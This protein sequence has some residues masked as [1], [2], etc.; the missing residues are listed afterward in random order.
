[1]SLFPIRILVV[2]DEPELCILSK[3]FLDIPG[4]INVDIAYSV[5]EARNALANVRY[6][7]IVSDYQMAGEDGIQ[8]LKSLRS[9]GDNTPF[10]LFTGK[11]REE[12]VI[13]AL[14]NGA[15]AYLQKGGMPRPMYAELE[16]RIRAAAAKRLADEENAR[17]LSILESTMESTADGILVADGK[18]GIVL[19]NK[20][21]KK[22][23]GIPEDIIQTKDDDLVLNFVI[24]QLKEPDKFIRTVRDL[25]SVPSKISFDVLELNDGRVFE[26]YSQPQRIGESV[27]GRVWS[28]RDITDQRK[29]HETLKKNE[30]LYHS[31]LSASPDVIIITDLGGH[32]IAVSPIGLTMFGHKKDDSI[33]GRSI[34]EY[35]VPG[36]RD[37]ASSGIQAMFR[38]IFPGPNEYKALRIDGGILDIEVNADLVREGDG[39]PTGLIIV[40]RD[41]TERKRMEQEL[42]E[43]EEFHRQLMSNLSMGVAIIDPITRVIE[44]VNE[45]ASAM[46]G[47]DKEFIEGNRCHSFLCPASEGACPVCDL[48]KEVDNSERILLCADGSRRSII[49]TVKKIN[50]R[51]QQ[52][53]L[54]CFIDITERKLVEEALKDSEEKF[55][56]IFDLANDA[57]RVHETKE[58]GTPSRFVDVNE[59][60][61]RMLGY[62]REEMLKQQPSEISTGYFDPSFPKILDSL[63]TTGWAKF[64]TEHRHKDGTIIPVEINAH[65]VD[66]QGKQMTIAVVRDISETKRNLSALKIANQKLNLLSSITRHDIKNQLQALTGYMELIKYDRTEI[67]SNECLRKAE[68]AA[69]RISAMIEFT[70]TYEDIGVN[71]PTWHNVR[72]MVENCSREIHAGHIAMVNEIPS[73]IEI[74]SDPLIIKVFYNLMDNAVRHGGPTTIRIYLV[75]NNGN[76]SIVCEDDGMGINDEARE[77]LFTKGSGKGHGLGLFLSREIL[78]ITGIMITEN[79]IPGHGAKFIM[80]IPKD[81]IRLSTPTSPR[82]MTAADRI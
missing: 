52:K 33:E 49:K 22:M 1:M 53:L 43:S 10:I 31:I 71:A 61:C 37:R 65:L 81:G 17:T 64:V 68:N 80:T 44:N 38:G 21:F 42:R 72:E 13:E 63:R 26:R 79:G 16:H 54:E 75:E 19:F 34:M 59:M 18:G 30:A 41:I 48:G 2:D 9:K 35:L 32:V 47:A 76:K 7:V 58:D 55:R 20:I 12:V 8:F 50:V 82:W 24:N 29:M 25:Y 15:D 66:L 62:T 45:A 77:D 51:G 60:A 73:E 70:K 11:G 3:E 74:F 6:Q 39:N 40:I 46:F 28:F 57:I 23:W 4:E 5:K 36:E 27:S 67:H 69:E 14:N 56:E 78:A